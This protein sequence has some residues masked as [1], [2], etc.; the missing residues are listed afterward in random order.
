M[1]DGSPS[2]AASSDAAGAM[3]AS[4][5]AAT[6]ALD[7]AF[8]DDP[9]L[10]ATWE[11]LQTKTAEQIRARSLDLRQNIRI[12]RQDIRTEDLEIRKLQAELRAL[13]EHLKLNVKLP[14]LVANIQEVSC[15]IRLPGGAGEERGGGSWQARSGGPAAHSQQGRLA[16][17]SRIGNAGRGERLARPAR[18]AERQHRQCA[19]MTPRGA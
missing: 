14:F 1:A 2:K 6:A 16:W 11:S 10:A 4:S 12:S 15:L 7:A 5:A 9:E 13:K 3:A 18:A 17:Q 8:A 19:R